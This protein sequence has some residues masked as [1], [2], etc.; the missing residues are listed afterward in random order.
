MN[1]KSSLVEVDHGS[2]MRIRERVDVTL[3]LCRGRIFKLGNGSKGWVS[4]NYERLP[5]VCYWCGPLNHVD[6]DCDR[7]IQSNGTLTKEDQEYGPWLRASP[8]PVHNNSV[9]VVPGYYKTKKKEIGRGSKQRE[10]TAIGTHGV[11]CGRPGMV[12]QGGFPVVDSM[13]EKLNAVNA[14]IIV[15]DVMD[16]THKGATT[17]DNLETLQLGREARF[18]GDLVNEKI[19]EIDSELKKFDLEKDLM[20]DSVVI[21]E[22]D[23]IQD[24]KS[25]YC[26]IVTN[27]S[28]HELATCEELNTKGHHVTNNEGSPNVYEPHVTGKETKDQENTHEV[29]ANKHATRKS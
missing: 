22:T 14:P 1:K 21:V 12:V 27:Q 4:F 5:N 2:V 29:V 25:E 19:C 7:W 9:V 23:S 24:G 20:G 8:S 13:R 28:H 15:E 3:P 10:E 16:I 17:G 6:R 11:A 18:Q 26:G